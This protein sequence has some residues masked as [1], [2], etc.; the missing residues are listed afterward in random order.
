MD[1]DDVWTKF[2]NNGESVEDLE[3]F[4]ME[5][6][7]NEPNK[8]EFIDIK[9][10]LYN[11]KESNEVPVCGKLNISTKTKLIYL[12]KEFDLYDFFWKLKT[13]D[14]D[15]EVEGIVKKQMKFNFINSEQ[16]KDFENKIKNENCVK[17]KILNQINNPNGRV[18]FKDVRKVDIGICKNDIQNL[19][20]ESNSKKI[21]NW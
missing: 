6:T 13:C 20:K 21:Q 17:I 10:D 19:K 15:E 3:N 1:I 5:G 4:D 2:I 7:M 11:D 8:T 12:N 18:T 14:Y 9:S 16:V